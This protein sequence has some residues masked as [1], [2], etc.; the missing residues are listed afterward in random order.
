MKTLLGSALAA[1]LLVAGCATPTAG[2]PHGSPTPIPTTSSRPTAPTPE[3]SDTG[4]SATGFP[5]GSL[6]PLPTASGGGG[7]LSTSA[8]TAALMTTTETGTGFTETTIDTRSTAGPC[9]AAGS[10]TGEDTVPSKVRVGAAF[11]AGSKAFVAEILTV[12]TDAGTAQRALTFGASGLNCTKG[13]LHG[14]DGT[15]TPATI[16]ASGT[17]TSFDDVAVDEVRA[18]TVTTSKVNIGLI[19]ARVGNALAAIQLGSLKG[20][21]TSELRNGEVIVAGALRKVKA[22]A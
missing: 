21:D 19:V 3:P 22:A 15:N 5:S 12:Y 4:G 1:A 14:T 6:T 8:A 10:P 16:K 9:K 20:S 18:W 11:A 13:T 2:D 7:L 17:D